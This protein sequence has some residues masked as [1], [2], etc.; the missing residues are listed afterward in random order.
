M[1]VADDVDGA[2][3][4]AA[5]KYD[6]SSSAKVNDEGLVVYHLRIGL[7]VLAVPGLVGGRHAVLELGGPVDLTGDQ[8]GLVEQERRLSPL[9]EHEALHLERLLAEGGKQV[10]VGARDGESPSRPRIRVYDHR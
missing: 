10:W 2:G 1:C 4:T 9:D 7:P 5:G 8:N 3:V 6:E